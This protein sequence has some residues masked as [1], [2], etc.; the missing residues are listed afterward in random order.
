MKG[1]SASFLCNLVVLTFI[2]TLNEVEEDRYLYIT[3]MNQQE[4][5]VSL[6]TFCMTQLLSPSFKGCVILHLIDLISEMITVG[7]N[8]YSALGRKI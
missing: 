8:I 4:I 3:G 5:S 6:S 1:E 7:K 2:K